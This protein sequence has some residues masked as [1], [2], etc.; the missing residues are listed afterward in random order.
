MQTQCPYCQTIYRVSAAHLNIAQGHVRCSHCRNIFNASN[1]LVKQLSKQTVSDQSHVNEDIVIESQDF[2]IPDLLKEDIYEPSHGRSWGSFF[3]WG[4]VFIVLTATL[5]GQAMWV[6]QRDKI[7]QHEEVRPWLE[8]FC[9]TFLCTL[10]PTRDLKSFRMQEH[11]A[12]VHPDID[13]AIQFE[14]TFINNATFPQPYPDL[15]LTFEDAN[16]NSLAQRRFKPIEYLQQP[17]QKDQQMRPKGS[18]HIKL[19]LIDMGK[20]IEEG[21]I[22]E[23]YHFEFF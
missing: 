18:V 12:Q 3:F 21:K 23:G 15:Q 17:P 11:V 1:H 10:P 19:I 5:A 13:D 4:I 2:E 22:A 7:L 9:Y 16:S 14:A 8:R 20:V 6:W